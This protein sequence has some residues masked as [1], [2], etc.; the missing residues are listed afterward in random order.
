MRCRRL[1]KKIRKK[2]HHDGRRGRVCFENVSASNRRQTFPWF[3]SWKV[4]RLASWFLDFE[5][6]SIF[7]S[8]KFRCVF[9]WEQRDMIENRGVF[10]FFFSTPEEES[11]P[12]R[13]S[14]KPP[15]QQSGLKSLKSSG[16]REASIEWKFS[17]LRLIIRKNSM[18]IAKLAK[19]FTWRATFLRVNTVNFRFS[20][21]PI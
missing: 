5:F 9:S 4:T 16:I 20:N 17:P 11:Y 10:H 21:V 7:W 3:G 13:I 19:N 12:S 8:Q 1:G 2:S 6:S 14:R 15:M 18:K